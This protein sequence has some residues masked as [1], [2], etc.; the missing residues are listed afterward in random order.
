MK[1]FHALSAHPG[2]PPPGVGPDVGN[3][4]FEPC[5]GGMIIQKRFK[6]H[7]FIYAEGKTGGQA[8]FPGSLSMPLMGVRAILEARHL[9]EYM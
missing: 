2:Q 5:K 7:E 1:P 8:D 3:L 6:R 4:R 9:L